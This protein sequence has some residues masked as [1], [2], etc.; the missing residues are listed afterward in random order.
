MRASSRWFRARDAGS[1][2]ST[3]FFWRHA[4]LSLRNANGCAMLFLMNDA[5]KTLADILDLI[6]QSK[7]SG[8]PAYRPFTQRTAD[9]LTLG[10]SRMSLRTENGQRIEEHSGDGWAI[11][12]T[13]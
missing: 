9:I 7:R 12:L 4:E 11:W 10:G 8:Q 13:K 2:A 6:N 5:A 1:A 3:D